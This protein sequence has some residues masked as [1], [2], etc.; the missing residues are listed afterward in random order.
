MGQ[1][2]V[3]PSG[4]PTAL[5]ST[6]CN[7]GAVDKEAAPMG[8]R[9]RHIAPRL[10]VTA[11]L[12]FV[13]APRLLST[14]PRLVVTAPRLLSTGPDEKCLAIKL[15]PIEQYNEPTIRTQQT[16]ERHGSKVYV[17]GARR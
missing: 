5:L 14:A 7:D 13:T 17:G 11:P 6:E 3:L 8:P 9:H 4:R 1:P 15:T 16:L 2:S 12:L 10:F